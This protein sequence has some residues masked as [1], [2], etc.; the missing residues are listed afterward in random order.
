[1]T[2]GFNQLDSSPI[3][4]LHHYIITKHGYSYKGIWAEL[5][6][7]W[8]DPFISGCHK[9]NSFNDFVEVGEIVDP[10]SDFEILDF[11]LSEKGR[12]ALRKRS[13]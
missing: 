7:P 9:L 10:P 4:F 2:V 1:T 13:S 11:H 8:A 6:N 5:E 12:V 3:C